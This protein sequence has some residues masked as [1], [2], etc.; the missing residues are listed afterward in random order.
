MSGLNPRTIAIHEA[1]H[2]VVAHRLGIPVVGMAI[3]EHFGQTGIQ[4]PPAGAGR[5][6]IE[7]AATVALAGSAA[8]AIYQ[9]VPYGFTPS[10]EIFADETR[11]TDLIG[12]INGIT[13]LEA[14][15]LLHELADRASQL[16]TDRHNWTLVERLADELLVK[17]VLTAPD[18]AAIVPVSAL[19]DVG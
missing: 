18:V 1:G 4:P 3:D 10:V 19:D 2:A 13:T 5:A 15:A 12:L 6:R 17:G 16:L 7:R 14:N 11:A 8:S 9:G